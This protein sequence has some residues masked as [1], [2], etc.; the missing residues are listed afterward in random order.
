[1]SRIVEMM[2][3]LPEDASA[4]HDEKR[5]VHPLTEPA[6]YARAEQ[7]AAAAFQAAN[8][9]R[10]T[11]RRRIKRMDEAASAVFAAAGVARE[12]ADFYATAVTADVLERL[13]R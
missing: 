3:K 7:M 8:V 11:P 1:M 2:T 5:E 9:A 10:D 13:T 12:I 6:L 4:P